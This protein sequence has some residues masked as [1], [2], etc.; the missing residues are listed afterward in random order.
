[1]AEDT[2][3][4]G[5]LFTQV[6][7]EQSLSDKVSDTLLESI[8]SRRLQ[9]GDRL[10]T[11][12]IL[13]EQFGVSRTVIREAVR[14]LVAKGVIE[15]RSGSGLRVAAVEAAAVSDFMSMF[16]RGQGPMNYEKVHEVRAMIE[17]QISRVACERAT[18]RDLDELRAA[19]D[20]MERTTEDVEACSLADVGFHRTI[21]KI[22]HNELY[23][24]MLDSI[25]DVLLDVRRATVG[26]PD[27]PKKALRYHRTILERIAERD[28]VGAEASMREHLD[29]SVS[30]WRSLGSA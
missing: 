4:E 24:V 12:R 27:R 15:V 20:L 28:P 7:R 17:V 1:M 25:S 18:P 26:I 3:T 21:A 9:P 19:Y 6:K 2:A 10:P 30:V 16:L 14:S 8:L 29:E 23:I 13:G 11:E 5:P 22:T